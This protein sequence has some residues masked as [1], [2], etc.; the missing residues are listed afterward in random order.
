M[1]GRLDHAPCVARGA[2]RAAF[3]RKGNQKIVP[4]RPAPGA[5]RVD[6]TPSALDPARAAVQLPRRAFEG[7]MACPRPATPGPALFPAL[8]V[9]AAP[10]L[11]AARHPAVAVAPAASA[12]ALTPEQTAW[13]A[14]HHVVRIGAQSNCS[15]PES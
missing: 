3:A 4:A 1:R 2:Y 14:Q 8:I 6:L 12:V 11:V 13:L 10:A 9:I 5:A 15:F 7:L